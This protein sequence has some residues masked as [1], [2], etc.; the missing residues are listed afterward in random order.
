MPPGS[1]RKTRL[2]REAHRGV[3]TEGSPGAKEMFEPVILIGRPGTAEIV[4]IAAIVFFLFGAKKIPEFARSLGEAKREL[5]K[6]SQEEDAGARAR[7]QGPVPSE[8]GDPSSPE[9]AETG[10]PGSNSTDSLG[11]RSPK[12]A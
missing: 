12:G 2:L 8:E 3:E 6:A 7:D 5:E 4:I 1:K 10:G 9:A 11:V